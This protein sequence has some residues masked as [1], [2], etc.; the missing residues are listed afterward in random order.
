[1]LGFAGQIE[2][3]RGPDKAPGQYVVHAWSST[4]VLFLGLLFINPKYLEIVI[5]LG[6]VSEKKH[7]Q[8][9]YIHHKFSLKR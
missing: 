5:S 1:M 2:S 3:F 8:N 7:I 6:R 4:S 9:N